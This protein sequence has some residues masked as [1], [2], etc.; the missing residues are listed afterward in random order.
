MTENEEKILLDQLGK[1]S[2]L[3]SDIPP[4][5]RYG[6]ELRAIGGGFRRLIYGQDIGDMAKQAIRALRVEHESEM[7]ALGFAFGR[8]MAFNFGPTDNDS[9]LFLPDGTRNWDS[10]A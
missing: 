9:S 7:A 1:A 6:N 10:E 5:L 2:Y 8:I 4:T 3:L